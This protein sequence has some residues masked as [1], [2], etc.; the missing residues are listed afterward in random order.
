MSI[1]CASV[2][3][4]AW[5]HRRRLTNRRNIGMILV[6]NGISLFPQMLKL[7]SAGFSL[8]ILSYS[9]QHR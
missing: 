5:E 3:R 8:S 9:L 7:C 6:E 4:K 2:L 1:K